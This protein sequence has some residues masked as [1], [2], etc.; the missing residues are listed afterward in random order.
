MEEI[1]NRVSLRNYLA[2]T[3]SV[4]IKGENNDLQILHVKLKNE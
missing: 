1:K 3:N 2:W 4:F